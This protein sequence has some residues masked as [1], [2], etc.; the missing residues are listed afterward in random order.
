M[1]RVFLRSL[2]EAQCEA[3]LQLA[4][5]ARQKARGDHGGELRLPKFMLL[6]LEALQVGVKEMGTEQ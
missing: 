3:A 1:L 4:D 5:G 6:L 2:L